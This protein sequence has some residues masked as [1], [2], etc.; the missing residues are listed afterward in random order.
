MTDS[1]GGMG[2]LERLLQALQ[3]PVN[4]QPGQAVPALISQSD[5]VSAIP[6]WANYF[7]QI[8]LDEPVGYWRFSEKT[9]S[10][11]TEC[12]D[13]TRNLNHGT[14]TGGTTLG[15]AGAISGSSDP[16]VLF[17][18]ST[19]YVATTLTLNPALGGF[20]LEA[21][22]K[23]TALTGVTQVVVANQDGTGT[24]R[25]LL[26]ID[27]TTG[28]WASDVAGTPLVSAVTASTTDY[29]HVVVTSDTVTSRLYVNGVEVING[30]RVPESATGAWVLGAAKTLTTF[31]NAT[32]DEI[33][34]YGRALT[35]AEV[36]RH[37]NAGTGTL[38]VAGETISLTTDVTLQWD[39]F[40]KRWGENVWAA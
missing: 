34:V 10:L 30:A 16:A 31:L 11:T 17:N 40:G 4:K 13:S 20:S 3:A 22:V 36:L 21:W 15:Q 1:I 18:G 37:Y 35:S 25:D 5:P 26:Y 7:L 24:G 27:G 9:A 6:T 12:R 23:T 8:M 29:V 32:A 2:E 33:A 14:Y 19:G 38:T 39:T 28:Y